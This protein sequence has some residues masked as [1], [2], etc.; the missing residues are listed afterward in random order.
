H[1]PCRCAPPLTTRSTSS[2][3]RPA[4]PVVPDP[5]SRRRSSGH[6]RPVSD[7]RSLVGL[8]IVLDGRTR[9]LLL[10]CGRV[11][12]CRALGE[13]GVGR[14]GGRE[15]G[16]EH[17]L[18]RRLLLVVLAPFCPG[19][20][21]AAHE[22]LVARRAVRGAG[23]RAR[24]GGAAGGPE[25]RGQRL[26][27]ERVPNVDAVCPRGRQPHGGPHGERQ[28]GER[29][30]PLRGGRRRRAGGRSGGARGGGRR[31]LGADGH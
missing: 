5:R 15:P 1:F 23:V 19:I 3:R 31:G 9:H 27:E 29:E 2:S 21:D 14:H 6:E 17:R 30:Q 4:A 25:C 8:R 26:R 24:R 11:R 28:R 12:S 10:Q 20:A 22:P 7:I 18:L 13:H 16:S